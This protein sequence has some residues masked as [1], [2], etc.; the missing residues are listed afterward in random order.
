MPVWL[1]CLVFVVSDIVMNGNEILQ[2]EVHD[3]E[4][5]RFDGN[6]THFESRLPARGTIPTQASGTPHDLQYSISTCTE[7]LEATDRFT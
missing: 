5:T 2:S 3:G 4:A 6:K 7:N 1:H